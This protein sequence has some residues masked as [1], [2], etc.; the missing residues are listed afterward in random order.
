MATGGQDNF[1]FQEEKDTTLKHKVEIPTI[2]TNRIGE[3]LFKEYG[4]IRSGPIEHFYIQ[5]RKRNCNRA[6]Q[7]QAREILHKEIVK[8]PQG[9]KKV[10]PGTTWPAMFFGKFPKKHHQV[11]ERERE[12][13]LNQKV[14]KHLKES[15]E[16]EFQ[17]AYEKWCQEKQGMLYDKKDLPEIH[18]M[19]TR[20]CLYTGPDFK[21]M[22]DDQDS[23][24]DM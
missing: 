13:R 8:L 4:D 22:E 2:D 3:I 1:S 5:I 11:T 18:I 12:V 15:V 6:W 19:I 9:W 20:C 24:M 16:M 14:R 23:D 10:K 17:G 21:Y 7:E